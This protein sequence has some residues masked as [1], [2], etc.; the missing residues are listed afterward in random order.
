MKVTLQEVE[1]RLF[2]VD[3]ILG[4]ARIEELQHTTSSVIVGQLKNER[5]RVTLE[6][7]DPFLVGQLVAAKSVY[8]GRVVLEY[9]KEFPSVLAQNGGFIIR[10]ARG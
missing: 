6:V 8:G 7:D 10:K 5:V 3:S 4:A 2:T 9:R 1:G